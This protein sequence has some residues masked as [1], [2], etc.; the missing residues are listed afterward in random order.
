MIIPTI[1]EKSWE[2][3]EKKFEIYKNFAKAVHIDFLDGKFTDNVTF[4]ETEP[5]KKYSEYFQLEAH[6]M[7]KEPMDYL[8]GLS[9]A[10]FRTFLGHVE[11]MT[12]QVEFVAKGQELGEVGLAIDIETSLDDIS[13]PHDD[14]DR[15]LLMGIMAGDSGRPFDERVLSKIKELSGK[16]LV[17]IQVDGGVSDVTLPRLKEA[18]ASHFCVNSYLFKGN[19]KEQFEKLQTILLD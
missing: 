16:G 9:Q 12:D 15:V 7:V 19:P 11:K 18:G 14:L 6:L 2:E 17:K 3:I 13:V 8:D 1:L 10:G 5:F 4:L